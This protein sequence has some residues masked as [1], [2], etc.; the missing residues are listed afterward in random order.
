MKLPKEKQDIRYF[1]DNVDEIE[2]PAYVC[3]AIF[4]INELYDLSEDEIY[5]KYKFSCNSSES[6]D[7]KALFKMLI[8]IDKSDKKDVRKKYYENYFN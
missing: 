8:D 1:V 3:E 2:L 4:D 7:R 5:E 6:V